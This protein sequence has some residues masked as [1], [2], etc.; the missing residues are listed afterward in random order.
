MNEKDIVP[1]GTIGRRSFIKRLGMAGGVAALPVGALLS[2]ESSARAD[3]VNPRFFNGRL[4]AG[5]AAILRFLAAAEI[6]EADL[7]QQYNEL[8]LGNESYQ[9]ALNILDGDEAT[10]VNL[11]TRDEI[12]HASFING[13]LQ[14]KGLPAVSLEAFRKL[15]SSQATGSDKTAKRLTNLMNLTVDTSWYNRYRSALNPDFGAQF[16][17]LVNLV[18]VPGIPNSDLP[19][20]FDS[21]G[22]L[23]S[24]GFEVQF[25]ANVAGFHF[26]T[27]EEGGS[28]LYQSMLPKA[29]SPEVIQIIGAIGGTEIQ[30]FQTWQ[31]K[32]GNALTVVDPNTGQV[33]FPQLPLAP[34]LPNPPDG[35]DNAAPNDTNQIFPMPCEF[36]A[37][38]L[39]PCSVIRPI[40]DKLAGAVATIAFFS[41]MGLF[42]GQSDEF[43]DVVTTLAEE[44]DEAGRNR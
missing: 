2:S 18:N 36:I 7:W 8:A 3:F 32:A 5:D 41:D 4:S 38:G 13:Y 24:S 22:N 9:L 12:S 31:D 14:S 40:S 15:P 43:F 11:N 20:P 16:A 29:N 10:Y 26:A 34:A 30:H 33:L 44:A 6:L 39:P 27:V 42:I 25:I 19:S 37:K 23:T 1:K 17:Q 28:S 21:S 35:T